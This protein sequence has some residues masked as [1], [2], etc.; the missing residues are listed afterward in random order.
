MEGLVLEFYH[1]ITSVGEPKYDRI[2]NK[3]K[4]IKTGVKYKRTNDF[5][6][7]RMGKNEE[8]CALPGDSGLG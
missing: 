8:V 7:A 2:M 5:Q 3:G 6:K 4:K 1:T